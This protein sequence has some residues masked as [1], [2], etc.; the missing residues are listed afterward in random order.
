LH[1]T[2]YLRDSVLNILYSVKYIL[3][4]VSTQSSYYNIISQ[5]QVEMARSCGKGRAAKMGKSKIGAGHSNRQ[6]EN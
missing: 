5:S 1:I 4:A 6:R 2:D 3:Q